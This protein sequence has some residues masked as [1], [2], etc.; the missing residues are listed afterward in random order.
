M[1]HL[2]VLCLL[3]ALAGCQAEGRAHWS[4]GHG[5]SAERP[6][7]APAATSITPIT[8]IAGGAS[9]FPFSGESFN[10]NC[11]VTGT[12]TLYPAVYNGTK[13][14]VWQN[15]GCQMSDAIDTSATCALA[16]P[17]SGSGLT[18]NAFLTGT[19]SVASCTAEA[20]SGPAPT[21]RAA[22]SSGPGS[23]TVTSV[24]CGTGLTCTPS[25]ITST[26]TVALTSSSTTVNGQTCSLGGS[27]TV[28]GA[29]SGAAGGA[30][31]GTY[32]NPTL[33]SVVAAASCAYPSSVTYNAGGQITAC[34]AGSAP[35]SIAIIGGGATSAIAGGQTNYFTTAGVAGTTLDSVITGGNIT[36]A[37]T[38]RNLYCNAETSPGGGQT[39]TFTVR[40]YNSGS[41]SST[42]IT[43]QVSGG[44]S[45]ATCSDTSN[46]QAVVAGDK[47][48]IAAA[49]SAASTASAVTCSLELAF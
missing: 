45:P 35:A 49:Q 46:T 38:V 25:P 37:A 18:W 44:S 7:Y 11:T 40:R 19:G 23:G 29:P 47:I 41:W 17:L 43:C 21:S 12:V 24:A 30:L 15:L 26:G 6:T 28:T 32:P 10:V 2:G 16:A 14:Q 33:A 4:I 42:A 36:R 13:W 3:L 9:G 20:R 34:T 39:E 48:G 22:P 5:E 27:C 31:T 8:T 1:N